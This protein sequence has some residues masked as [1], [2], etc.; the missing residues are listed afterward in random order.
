MV[1]R[2]LEGLSLKLGH[3]GVRDKRFG[4]ASVGPLGQLVPQAM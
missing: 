4:L 1:I 3:Q 2:A